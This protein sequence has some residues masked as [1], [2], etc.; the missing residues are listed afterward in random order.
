[1]ST[2]GMLLLAIL[3]LGLFLALSTAITIVAPY[4]SV[5]VVILLMG[6]LIL[7]DKDDPPSAT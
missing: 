3:A 2:G 5:C 6:W 1:M 7:S 4:V